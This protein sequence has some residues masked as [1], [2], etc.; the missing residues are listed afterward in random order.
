VLYVFFPPILLFFCIP[1]FAQRAKI[2]SLKNLLPSLHDT[3][4]V[5]CLNVLSLAY[6]Y[7]NIDTAKSFAQ[8]AFS[9]ASALNYL[10]GNAMSLNNSARIAGHG[11][12]NF[13]LQEK[14]SLETIQLYKNGKDE[15]VIAETYMNMALALFCQ[16][17]FERSKAACNTVIQLSKKI[18]DKK[19]VGEALSV[20]GS[21]NLET[22]NYEKSF[23]YFNESLG[24][25]KSINDPYNTSIL[26]S[27]VGDLYRLAGDQKTA[28][29]FYFQSLKY[30]KGSSLLWHPLVDLGDT[31]YSLEP[32]DSASYDQEKYIQT[33]KSLTVKSNYI[34]YPKIRLAEMHIAYKEYDKA[35]ALLL[36]ELKVS[37][38]RNE[39]QVMR[40]LLDIGRAYE[41][42]KDYKKAF[43]YAKNLLQDSRKH[44]AKQYI[45]D[46]YRLMYILYDQQH[47]VD[48][49]Y[50]YYR[51]YTS[52]KDS[53]DVDEFSK[54]LAIYKAAKENDKKQA[55]I[56]LLN[57]E[58]LVNQ[59]QLQLSDQ[60]L[61]SGLFQKN[62]LII[63]V[64]VLVLLGFIIFRNVMLKQ[65]NEA[66]RHEIIKQELS[67]KIDEAL[68]TKFDNELYVKAVY[69]DIIDFNKYFEQFIDNVNKTKGSNQY[70]LNVGKP[71][72]YS[73]TF[74]NAIFLI[75]Q[76]KIANDD[77]R[78]KPF[79]NLSDYMQFYL[80]P[81]T[82]DYS[83][84]NV[85]W[86]YMAY[87]WNVFHERFSRI[88]AIKEAIEKQLKEKFEEEL[89]KIY[90]K[91]YV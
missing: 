33:I 20:L 5:D 84:F 15:K 79:T 85:E 81:E 21:I 64:I 52:M 83:K 91:Y 48:S 58:N 31:Y 44:N 69:N 4:R 68:N 60:Q 49:A 63:G 66:H 30:P 51:K 55:Q 26:L 67:N 61:K 40:L 76:M 59:Q 22:G 8:K 88:P 75:Y 70:T 36:E 18:G 62:I 25:F 78:L 45:R 23:E 38:A 47:Q 10:R 14:I 12:H 54:K 11:L 34:T 32:F 29:N 13:P 9:E 57:N 71:A 7:L 37:R 3:A 28:L 46:G 65:K 16:S 2:D 35:I 19:G 89:S 56:E 17:Y 6:S 43:A 39:N 86:L 82:F 87:D 24:M 41:G 27:K 53:V 80:S 74:M 72:E 42:K 1:L 73:H 77:E 50:S 90:A